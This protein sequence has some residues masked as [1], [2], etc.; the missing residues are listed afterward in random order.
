MTRERRSFKM[1]HQLL[2]DVIKRQAG[3]LW[4]AASEGIM[5]FI[6]SGASKGELELTRRTLIIRDNGKGFRS[7]DDIENFFEVFGKPH[8]ARE[9]KTF[10]RFRMGRGQLFAFGHNIWRSGEF[11]MNINIERDGLDYHL[12]S[13]LDP[14]P[15][16]TITIQLYDELSHTQF[17]EIVEQIKANCKYVSIPIT[18]NDKPFAVDCTKVP[19]DLELP[20]ADIRFKQ[21]QDLRV[22]NQGVKVLSFYRN[23]YGVG[24]DV[25]TKKPIKVNFARNDIMDSC[26]IWKAI[27]EELA[28]K[29]LADR[30]EEE[31]P[32][33][34][35]RAATTPRAAP[36]RLTEQDHERFVAQA[37]DGNIE[38][39]PFKRARIYKKYEQRA[40]ATIQ[41][42]FNACNGKVTMPPESGFSFGH[43]HEVEQIHMNELACVLDRAMLKRWGCDSLEDIVELANKRLP[44]R[45]RCRLTYMPW[46]DLMVTLKSKCQL[47]PDE[48][49][50]RIEKIVLAVL[51]ENANNA[52]GG[53]PRR[54][55]G[56]DDLPVVKRRIVLGYGP[57]QSWTDGRTFIA[58]NRELVRQLKTTPSAWDYYL[59][60][61]RHE[62]LH[63]VNTARNHKHSQEFFRRYH[64]W[65]SNKWHVGRFAHLCAADL[66]RIAV[67]VNEQADADE[68][69]FADKLEECARAGDAVAEA[70]AAELAN[71]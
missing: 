70:G 39:K 23:R 28:K 50:I 34:S 19:W 38:P 4:K 26:P 65:Y 59:H 11:E 56:D 43:R 35:R 62:G 29:A 46:D 30:A 16:C 68:L 21:N 55:D 3:S 15:G 48:Q 53:C 47:V 66:P 10:G 41:Q 31:T 60:V 49:L 67:R 2:L 42:V 61:L 37:K 71:T 13:G 12:K 33:S 44:A 32:V 6:D 17:A 22:Y 5:N 14:H 45:D 27:R 18:L 7:R 64:E 69:Y 9:A 52:L 25:V 8:E 20:F 1:D 36:K 40:N 63:T 58:I 54:R 24:G 51:R 57:R